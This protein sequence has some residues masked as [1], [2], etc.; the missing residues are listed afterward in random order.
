MSSTFRRFS[1]QAKAI[2]CLVLTLHMQFVLTGCGQNGLGFL[3]PAQ[4]FRIPL[5]VNDAL[6]KAL[7]GTPFA[8]AFALDIFPNEQQF[9]LALP[10]ASQKLSGK[11]AYI[12]GNFTITEFYVQN[13][14]KSATI[15]LDDA[16]HV[17]RIITSDGTTWKLPDD[18]SRVS[19]A[20]DQIAGLDA[21]LAANAGLLDV[22]EQLDAQAAIAPTP[23][24]PAP[25]VIVNPPTGTGTKA[26]ASLDEPLRSVLLIISSIWYPLY[27]I[28]PALLAIFSV[29]TVLQNALVLRFDGDWAASNAGSQLMVKIAGGK[30]S[31]LVDPSSGQEIAISDSTL[32]TVDG[33]RVVWSVDANVLG[34]STP[35]SFEFDVQEMANG[36]LKGTLTTIGSSFA[37]VPV[38]MTRA[39]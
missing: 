14:G 11:Y 30:I 22:A 1:F 35:V 18:S 36:S 16:K 4:Q 39:Q 15:S 13:K 28:L 7:R 10:D 29:A 27:G 2:L 37:R 24:T 8:G 33:N 26:A 17:G 21:Y 5:S 38:T 9:G 31:K 19:A 3:T 12:D 6:S 34:Q 20:G 32:K 25:T 23:S